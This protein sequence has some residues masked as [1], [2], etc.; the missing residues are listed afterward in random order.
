VFP[1]RPAHFLVGWLVGWL[2]GV[3]WNS[4]LLDGVGA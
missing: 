4:L 1:A 2:V 3:V